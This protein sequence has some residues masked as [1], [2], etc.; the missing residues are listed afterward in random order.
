[1]KEIKFLAYL[2]LAGSLLTFSACDDDDDENGSESGFSSLESPYLICAG[3]NPGGVVF[4]FK[5]DGEKGG[6]NY[7]DS[8][9]VEDF[10]Y[11]LKIRTIKGEKSDKTKGGA[12]FIQ[13][14]SSVQ[15]V[16]YSAVDTLCTGI[17]KFNALSASDLKEYTLASDDE[18]FDVSNLETGTTGAPLMSAL[19]KQYKKLVIGD[20]W[21]ATAKNEKAEDELIWIVKTREGQLV[22]FIVTDFPASPAPTASGYV[23]ITWD[24][25][26]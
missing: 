20:K 26:D 6:A 1:M 24:Y 18:S 15:A 11:D 22:K 12:P 9:T 25:L 21:K 7:T 19:Q 8:L 23:A 14:Y 16:N 2:L 5:Y 17:T 10:E 3:R 4:D 13:L